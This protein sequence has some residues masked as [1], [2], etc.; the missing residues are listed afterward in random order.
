[1]RVGSCVLRLAALKT[2]QTRDLASQ[3]TAWTKYTA[4]FSHSCRLADSVT[5]QKTG[6]YSANVCDSRQ[7]GRYSANVMY[8][9]LM[10]CCRW[11]KLLVT[12]PDEAHAHVTQ[13]ISKCSH[14]S[15]GSGGGPGGARLEALFLRE[16]NNRREPQQPSHCSSAH[17]VSSSNT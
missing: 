7:I 11:R 15:S 12:T 9:W 17:L 3:I 10:A 16:N 6:A 14:G 5:H 4:P 13:S 2:L 8:K 1:M